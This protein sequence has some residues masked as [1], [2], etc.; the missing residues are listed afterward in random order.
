MRIAFICT[1]KLPVPAVS[2]GA[3]Q[4]YIDGILPFLSKHHKITV[5]SIAH[6]SLLAKEKINE[7]RYIRV[8]GDNPEEY[9]AN[10][11]AQLTDKFDLVHIYNRPLWVPL[12]R[13]KIAKAKISLSLHNE[14]FF[15]EK[16][17]PET[18]VK[19]IEDV[20]FITTVSQFIA[21]GIKGNITSS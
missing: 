2:G 6:P 8:S 12:I 14:M 16:I 11:I 5:F 4:Q 3:I 15:L 21:D 7:V 18:A 20:A 1:E 19:C 17:P 9:I 13:Q 10:V